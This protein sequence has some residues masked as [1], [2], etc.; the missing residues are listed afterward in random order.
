M[1]TSKFFKVYKVCVY[2]E[3]GKTTGPIT[4]IAIGIC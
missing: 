3:Y 4:P 2:S 1:K